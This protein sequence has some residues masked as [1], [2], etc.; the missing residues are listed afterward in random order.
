MFRIARIGFY[1]SSLIFLSCGGGDADL[2]QS[3]AEDVASDQDG[4]FQDIGVDLLADS[5]EVNQDLTEVDHASADQ[6]NDN[7][8]EGVEVF[9]D[10]FTDIPVE[11]SASSDVVL[12]D[13]EMGELRDSTMDQVDLSLSEDGMVG[14]PDLGADEEMFGTGPMPT[15]DSF[16]VVQSNNEDVQLFYTEGT[17][18]DSPVS[19]LVLNVFNDSGVL[20]LEDFVVEL[21]DYNTV[22]DGSSYRSQAA[23]S[24][25]VELLDFGITIGSYEGRILDVDYNMSERV[26]TD[27]EPSILTGEAC[28]FPIYTD[29]YP[30]EGSNGCIVGEEAA[31][32]VGMGVCGSGLPPVITGYATLG[33]LY[34]GSSGFC[35]PAGD[36]PHGAEW[37]ITGTSNMTIIYTS[38]DDFTYPITALWPPNFEFNSGLCFSDGYDFTLPH[39]VSVIDESGNQSDDIEML[40]TL[41]SGGDVCHNDVFTCSPGFSCVEDICSTILET[42]GV[43]CEWAET[44]STSGGVVGETLIDSV[45]TDG[46]YNE[47]TGLNCFGSHTAGNEYIYSVG[48]G[49]GRTLNVTAIPADGSDITLMIF[50]NT[51]EYCTHNPLCDEGV[52]SGLG[53]E[54]ES[55][56]WTS[57]DSG[58]TN[59]LIVVDA[60]DSGGFEFHL[61]YSVE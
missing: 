12:L 25:V 42:E 30:C 29:S 55:L 27:V 53:G 34:D 9:E 40:F 15:L 36:F 33:F 59:V 45:I 21:N 18:L 5:E 1:I 10:T 7:S 11:D 43:G 3:I 57:T 31:L 20:V 24:G 26:T 60:I 14:S 39:N 61:E 23:I 32:D 22:Y 19:F 51:E 46:L 58:I 49:F 17:D 28:Y 2:L 48:M 47:Y 35:D 13:S 37:S 41:G 56:S 4:T 50:E 54:T 8:S 52:N 6:I 16:T 38:F 44:I